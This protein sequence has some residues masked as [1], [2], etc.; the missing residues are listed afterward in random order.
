MLVR[1][2]AIDAT[3]GVRFG[4]AGWYEPYTDH[5]GRLFRD[6]QR[7]FGRCVSKVYREVRIPVDVDPTVAPYRVKTVPVGWV[8]QKRSRY[9]DTGAPYM[10]ETWVEVRP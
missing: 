3:Q 10:L 1:E 9:E 5:R 7:E 4:D 8:F 6:Y 2:T